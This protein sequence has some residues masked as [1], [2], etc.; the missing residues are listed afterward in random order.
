MYVMYFKNAIKY[1]WTRISQFS[2]WCY[3]L[4]QFQFF[5]PYWR[6]NIVIQVINR[7][8]CRRRFQKSSFLQC[9][10][11]STR[12]WS[13][14]ATQSDYLISF[15][16]WNDQS[17][18]KRRRGRATKSRGSW[19][20]KSQQCARLDG[21]Q[22]PASQDV[23]SGVV[24]SRKRPVFCVSA[25]IRSSQWRTKRFGASFSL[26]AC[27][28]A[29]KANAHSSSHQEENQIKSASRGMSAIFCWKIIKSN[30]RLPNFLS[31]AGNSAPC[32]EGHTGPPSHGGPRSLPYYVS[33]PL[34]CPH[35]SV[36]VCVSHPHWWGDVRAA[37]AHWGPFI[38]L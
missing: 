36:C 2:V 37:P 31:V 25:C 10:S 17:G 6:N 30:K 28:V 12:F 35:F 8:S 13:C 7:P 15:R 3:T 38:C 27:D 14:C 23:A 18:I 16:S 22:L 26:G 34:V 29:L 21:A 5:S 20:M 24:Q 9:R 19:K 1:T 33:G 4:L 32:S 11:V